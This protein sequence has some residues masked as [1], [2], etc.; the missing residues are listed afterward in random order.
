M[1]KLI[2]L[3][4]ALLLFPLYAL[5]QNGG[6][7][8][9]GSASSTS[10]PTTTSAAVPSRATSTAATTP[11]PRGAGT[12][13]PLP[14]TTTPRPTATTTHVNVSPLP[15][16]SSAAS[17]TPL[18]GETGGNVLLWAILAAIVILPFGFLAAQYFTRTKTKDDAQDGSGCFN[19]K[20]LMEQKLEEIT[21]L[22]GM[23]VG[24]VQDAARE[25]VSQALEGTSA[26]A[27][28]ERLKR[29]EAAYG[30]LTKMYEECMVEFEKTAFKGVIVEQSLSDKGVL[31]NINIKKTYQ[32]GDWTLNNVLV[33]AKQIPELSKYLA[34][35]PWYIHLWKPS[36]DDIKVVFKNKVFDI[37]LSDKS[38]WGPAVAYGRSIGIPLEQLDFKVK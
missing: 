23:L 10:V 3:L 21:D 24:K 13:A 35:G 11:M 17:T 31:K 22:K 16:T 6:P 15:A 4:L 5:A 2:L 25:K 9:A 7:V 18:A 8:P 19:L 14:A 28:L 27:A 32:S 37:R 34:D 26:G 30:K 12:P 36:T 38:T 33:S 1:K 20:K 29:A